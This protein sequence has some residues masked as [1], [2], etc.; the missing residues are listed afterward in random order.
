MKTKKHN[1]KRV[2]DFLEKIDFM[3][4]TNNH[5][6]DI[7]EKKDQPKEHP[8]LAAEVIIDSVYKD[9]TIKLYP[10]FWE[11]SLDLQRKALL[12]ELVH[13]VLDETRK[14]PCELLNGNLITPEQITDAN[15][16]ATTRITHF[17]D[18]LFRDRLKY[19]KIAYK[20]YLK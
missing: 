18:C 10:H 8:N 7:I 14:L 9:L 1:L 11:L 12:H 4:L 15:E 17:I 3:F 2:T 16:K 19:A 13:T 6:R 20:N 5:E